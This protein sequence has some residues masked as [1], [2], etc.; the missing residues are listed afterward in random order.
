LIINHDKKFIFIHVPKTGGCSI[1]AVLH[2]ELERHGSHR[3]IRNLHFN[4]DDYF[5]FGFVRNPWD[6]MCSL[7]HFCIQKP[8]KNTGFNQSFIDNGFKQTLMKGF[9][10]G[11]VDA[12]KWL[13]GCDFVCRF[14]NFQKDFDT[15]C[16]M[17]N[18][19]RYVVPVKNKSEHGDYHQYYDSEMIDFVRD[20]HRQ[21]IE[22]FGYSF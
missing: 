17:G 14:E 18:L 2:G 11:Q 21:T 9:D 19:G 15:A 20:A 8:K 22:R 3:T 5:K 10:S 12:M 6:R 4:T 7:Y 13:D 16:D 1:K